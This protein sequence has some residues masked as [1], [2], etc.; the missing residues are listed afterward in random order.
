MRE[1][2]DARRGFPR[3]PKPERR[4]RVLP[5]VRA[6]HGVADVSSG[7][8]YY[9]RSPV[10]DERSR[11]YSP[12]RY[13]SGRFLRP[14]AG[15]VA[16][17][18]RPDR[19]DSLRG[20]AGKLRPPLPPLPIGPPTRSFLFFIATRV[21]DRLARPT[22]RC[23]RAEPTESGAAAAAAEGPLSYFARGPRTVSTLF[24]ML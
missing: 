6:A 13:R 9:F 2:V 7:G 12:D 17:A 3:F 22:R 20:E 4:A 10:D 11:R 14:A 18:A 19:P 23:S 8:F 21:C 5:D 16:Y 1:D 15:W 24:S